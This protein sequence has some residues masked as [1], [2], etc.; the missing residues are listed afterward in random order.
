[1]PQASEQ[2]KKEKILVNSNVTQYPTFRK[3]TKR[4]EKKTRC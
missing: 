1:M 4:E 3:C 2:M